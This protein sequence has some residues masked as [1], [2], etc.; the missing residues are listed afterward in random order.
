[1][2]LINNKATL[3][4]FYFEKSIKRETYKLGIKASVS[5]LYSPCNNNE[6]VCNT[7]KEIT[8]VKGKTLPPTQKPGSLMFLLMEQK[9]SVVKLKSNIMQG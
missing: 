8:A 7:T 1:M 4:N 5:G 3:I 6:K 9:I 2:W